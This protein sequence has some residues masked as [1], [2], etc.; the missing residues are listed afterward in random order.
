M[1]GRLYAENDKE[2]QFSA[3]AGGTVSAT[4]AAGLA[5][6]LLALTGCTTDFVAA[7][8]RVTIAAPRKFDVQTV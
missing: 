6:R 3:L 5:I 8:L 2:L 4:A 7:A 1:S